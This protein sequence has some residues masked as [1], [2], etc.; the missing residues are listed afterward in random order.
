MSEQDR[1]TFKIPFRGKWHNYYKI[2]FF[3]ALFAILITILFFSFSNISFQKY[4]TGFSTEPAFKTALPYYHDFDH[5]G[6][7]ERFEL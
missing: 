2:Y 6:F 1:R 5:E 3:L 7:S 4:K